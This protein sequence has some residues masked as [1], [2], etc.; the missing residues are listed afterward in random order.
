M[1]FLWLNIPSYIFEPMSSNKIS[2]LARCRQWMICSIKNNKEYP[3]SLLIVPLRKEDSWWMM[4]ENYNEKKICSFICSFKL[5]NKIPE[6]AAQELH[7]DV[8][9]VLAF[10]PSKHLDTRCVM[11]PLEGIWCYLTFKLWT[12]TGQFMWCQQMLLC[13]SKKFTIF[14]SEIFTVRSLSCHGAP[15]LP[16]RKPSGDTMPTPMDREHAMG[17]NVNALLQQ[18]E[19][20]V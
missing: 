6:T 9:V 2:L 12:I 4:E 16:V 8:H 18:D 7:S 13:F 14:H 11:S 17:C 19:I 1:K 5:S 10:H 20:F 3:D 15:Q